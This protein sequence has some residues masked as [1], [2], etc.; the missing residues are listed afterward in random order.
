MATT[1]RITTWA[2]PS[3]WIARVADDIIDTGALHRGWIGVVAD[4]HNGDQV[5]VRSV[6]AGGPAARA[7][8]ESGDRIVSIDDTP[9]S[10][11]DDV[12]VRIR[13]RHPGDQVTIVT[14][15]DGVDDR[16]V[17]TISEQR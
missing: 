7:G 11:A 17:V 3:A 5:T 15:R 2:T 8:L 14:A 9:V 13:S 4:E 1:G 6:V 10:S 16:V 12:V